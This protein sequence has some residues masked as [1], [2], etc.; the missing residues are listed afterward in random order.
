MNC[1]FQGDEISNRHVD[2]LDVRPRPHCGSDQLGSVGDRHPVAET[3]SEWLVTPNQERLGAANCRPVEQQPQMAGDSE[4]S[5]M[6]DALPVDDDQID[7]FTELGEG[8]ENRGYL[9]KGEESGDVGKANVG[10]ADLHFDEGQLREPLDD[11][12]R[13]RHP[14]GQAN[15]DAGDPA[16]LAGFAGLD[17]LPAQFTLDCGRFCR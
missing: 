1:C 10:P 8:R 3:V 13:P 16:N 2:R 7:W 9:P 15:V 17:N 6:G 5:R 14:P 12:G 11:D 4:T